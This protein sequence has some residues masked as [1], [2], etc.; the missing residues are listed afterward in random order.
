MVSAGLPEHDDRPSPPISASTAAAMT[1]GLRTGG[2]PLALAGW[3]PTR[4]RGTIGPPAAGC[5][6]YPMVV[7]SGWRSAA[8]AAP[9]AQ[10]SRAPAWRPAGAR[11]PAAR[12]PRPPPRPLWG[13]AGGGP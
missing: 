6:A 8:R 1:L 9:L 10:A 13:G 5:C 4:L 3:G 11:P 7:R 2:T 12:R